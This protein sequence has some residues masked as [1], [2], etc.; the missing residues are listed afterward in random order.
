MTAASQIYDPSHD[1]T[2]ASVAAVVALADQLESIARQA[3]LA[4]AEAAAAHRDRLLPA[5]DT[6]LADQVE[7]LVDRLEDAGYLS[8]ELYE[9]RLCAAADPLLDGLLPT[10]LPGL[11]RAVRSDSLPDVAALLS[12]GRELLDE[13]HFELDATQEVDARAE[14]RQR[15]AARERLGQR[16]S[17]AG[18]PMAD[19]PGGNLMAGLL[20]E[21]RDVEAEAEQDLAADQHVT[22]L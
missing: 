7:T 6:Q 13:I 9:D 19:A 18:L 1:E 3:R 14:A 20:R 2:P 10:L 8:A 21:W 11:A 12:G 4:I 22:L 17:V 5:T 15:I 16:A